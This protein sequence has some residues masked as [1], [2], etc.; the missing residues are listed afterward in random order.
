MKYKGL[1]KAMI[2]E[3]KKQTLW[4]GHVTFIIVLE[5]QDIQ[6]KAATHKKYIYLTVFLIHPENLYCGYSLEAPQ[7]AAFE[8]LQHVFREKLAE[9]EIIPKGDECPH[10]CQFNFVDYLSE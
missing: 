2:L 7:R 3:I 1:H 9:N 10:Y 8:Y 6:T 5:K 4:L